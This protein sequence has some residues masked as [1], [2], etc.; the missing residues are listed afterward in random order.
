MQQGEGEADLGVPPLR[1]AG[2]LNEAPCGS[3]N[4]GVTL[5]Y[6]GAREVTQRADAAALLA[7]SEV[8]CAAVPVRLRGARS[9]HSIVRRCRTTQAGPRHLPIGVSNQIIID[10]FSIVK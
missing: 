6:N 5:A 10:V 9:A 3:G 7:S 8:A 1:R 2:E 4:H